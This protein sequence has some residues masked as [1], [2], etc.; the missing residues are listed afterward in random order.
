M[1]YTGK[2]I[3]IDLTSGTW[4]I[5]DT[6]K[7]LQSK[8]IGAKGMGFALLNRM[9]PKPDP[10][11]PENPLIFINGPFTGTRVQTSARTTLVTKSPLTG[12]AL[13]SHCGGSFGPR[14]KFAGYD[15]FVITGKSAK[16]VYLYVTPGNVEIRDASH[17]WGKGIFETNDV[18]L[19]LH[20]GK[21]PRVAAIGPAGENKLKI[22]CIG[23]DKHRQYG[24]GGAG[25][26]MGSKNLKAVV[27]DG[28]LPLKYFD[29]T[30]FNEVNVKYTKEVLDLDGIKF[31]RQKGTMKC[32]RGCQNTE[33]L[34]T[35]NWSLVQFDDFEK[36]S[37][38]AARQE[39]NWEDT[40]CFSCAIRCSKWARWDGHEIEGPEYETAALFGSN[41]LVNNIKDI[42]WVNELCNDLGID[43]ISA[44]NI[45]GF[46][47]ECYEKKL[48][49][50]WDG[51]Q[52]KWGN[53]GAQREFVK[54]MVKRQGITNIFADGTRD[55]AKKIGKGSEDIA[56]NIFG[57]E[58]SGINP[59]GSLTMGVAMAVADF[60]SHTRLWI[61]ESENGPDFKIEDIVPAVSQGIDTTNVRNSLVI[62]D[63]VPLNLDK[64]AEILNA[65]TGYNHTG[66]SLL[67]IGTKIASLARTYNLKNGRKYTDDTLP[68]RFFNEESKGGFMK[69]KKLD[70]NYFDSFVK[71]YYKTKGW[72]EKGEPVEVF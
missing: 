68:G 16:P 39:L 48:L 7:E 66:N 1:S 46:A 10:L 14:M 32:I 3:Y 57:M 37:S 56:I 38:E 36:I 6:D 40:S 2:C 24:R 42:A 13:D 71:A 61:A 50:N 49:D 23:I 15:Y 20:P 58:L 22:A 54:R 30:K 41:C 21:D 59:L 5:Q 45:V 70:R 27:V 9:A 52:M 4:K 55:A 17:I 60:S 72:N 18:L 62:C 29:E 43:S 69:G 25:A 26:V 12:S 31:R 19:K 64:L 44:G 65:A 67:A 47:M 33:I 63:F 34:P 53:A 28:D 8:Y 51:L 11:S 35:K